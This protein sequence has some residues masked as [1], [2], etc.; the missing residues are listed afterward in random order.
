MVQCSGAPPA[1]RPHMSS[2]AEVYKQIVATARARD[3]HQ[4]AQAQAQA[5]ATGSAIA[6]L[7]AKLAGRVQELE[8]AKRKAMAYVQELLLD[9]QALTRGLQEDA[10]ARE[11]ATEALRQATDDECHELVEAARQDAAMQHA[12]EEE[13]KEARTRAEELKETV[14]SLERGGSSGEPHGGE[15][16]AARR[17]SARQTARLRAARD[18]LRA[19]E[20]AT[21]EAGAAADSALAGIQAAG[22]ELGAARDAAAQSAAV[23]ARREEEIARAE[24]ALAALSPEVRQ[25]LRS[26]AR[27]KAA[28]AEASSAAGGGEGAMTEISLTPHARGARRGDSALQPSPLPMRPVAHAA[29]GRAEER[30]LAEVLAE[31]T[32]DGAKADSAVINPVLGYE[33]LLDYVN[34]WRDALAPPAP[35]APPAATVVVDDRP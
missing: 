25:R 5:Q 28:A 22:T 24:R 30:P 9:K 2:K 18:E 35:P 26:E 3:G 14:E 10:A 27:A 12:A 1:T 6:A 29:G 16:E 19:A 21:S 11:Q 15:L 13:A 4:Q 32:I 17:A 20:V 7:E 23:V 33:A 31:W 34:D 8:T